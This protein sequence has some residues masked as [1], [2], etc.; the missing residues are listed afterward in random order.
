MDNKKKNTRREF[1]KT[2][3]LTASA[4]GLSS[5]LKLNASQSI[6]K[7]IN[8]PKY[9]VEWRNRVEEMEYR[10]LG[11]TGLMVSAMVIG[12]GRLNPDRYKYALTAIE[13][14]VNYIDT[15]SRYGKGRSEEG[16][17]KLMSEAGRE[18]IF[19]ATKLSSYIPFIDNLYKDIFK[20]L[21]SSRQNEIVKKANE[22][23]ESK[24]VRRP[25]YYFRFFNNQD[26]EFPEGYLT[27][28]MSLEF[29]NLE[30]WK[31]QIKKTLHETVNTS[32]KRLGTDYID[33]LECPHGIRLPEEFDDLA[34]SETMDEL[35]KAGKIR[36]AGVS[37]HTDVPNNLEKAAGTE[38]V[39]MAM[40]AYNIVNQS[41][42]DM[43]LRKAVTSGMGIIGMKAANPVM[44]VDDAAGLPD[45]RIE[46]LNMAIQE[47]WKLPQKAYL[48][49]LQN[50]D[51]SGV[52][53]D[54]RNAEMIEENLKVIGKNV[55]I[56]RI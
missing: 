7:N 21:P 17:G 50:K 5:G 27:Y 46:K 29:G 3:L 42:M 14:G 51:I 11:N 39:D 31:S 2:G 25:G 22:L 4:V 47:D 23:I 52:I 10:K 20:G 54:F 41:G 35:K 38:Y 8:R 26:N 49:V 45:W 12:G 18:K 19:L 55:E 13:R 43:P 30:K 9:S 44:R 16:A 36:F 34:I 56:Q 24:G 15:A 53:S 48:W 37:I 28:V 40:V 33:I 6:Q 1:I 32:L